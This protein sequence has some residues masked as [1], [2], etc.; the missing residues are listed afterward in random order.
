MGSTPTVSDSWVVTT[1][2]KPWRILRRAALVLAAILL[3]ALGIN[4][5][6]VQL[7]AWRASK[8]RTLA[9]DLRA[10]ED[11]LNPGVL[12]TEPT[13]WAGLEGAARLLRDAGRAAT[14]AAEEDRAKRLE[15]ESQSAGTGTW[16]PRTNWRLDASPARIARRAY[17][18]EMI[19]A[20]MAPE[21]R[22]E[23]ER[24]SDAAA[25]DAIGRLRQDYFRQVADA[26]SLRNAR[27]D[28]PLPSGGSAHQISYAHL[29]ATSTVLEERAATM[30][31]ARERD[32]D[33]E[34]FEA[35]TQALALLDMLARQP[36]VWSQM[37][38]EIAA[39]RVLDGVRGAII[40]RAREGTVDEAWLGQLETALRAM[41]PQLRWEPALKAVEAASL[42]SAAYVYESPSSLR[43]API[44]A[45]ERLRQHETGM[46]LAGGYRQVSAWRERTRHR[47]GSYTLTRSI[48]SGRLR[49]V[50]NSVLEVGPS[51]LP[52]IGST[53][54]VAA[55]V[56]RGGAY[57]SS[58]DPARI[59]LKLRALETMLA[60]ERWNLRQGEYPQQLTQEV[61]ALVPPLVS[62]LPQVERRIPPRIAPPAKGT[63]ASAS[64]ELD[65]VVRRMLYARRSPPEGD[66]T[67]HPHYALYLTGPDGVDHGGVATERPDWLPTSA[68]PGQDFVLSRSSYK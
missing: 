19:D 6:L 1:L 32:D 26:A 67:Q 55:L 4:E 63:F 27:H 2:R 18:E 60:I 9:A 61:F 45:G 58:A 28:K 39:E 62:N 24:V 34:F 47:M 5:M 8:H 64:H 38:A 20:S 35:L 29:N 59:P 13:P 30:A 53:P 23:Y 37:R 65:D 33:A 66:K 54:Y 42:D 22:A 43:F 10:L 11:E 44:W 14:E 17:V 31:L 3:L 48:V 49:E 36:S 25:R 57:F 40:A 51:S 41:P 52:T 21:V 16:R 50:R 7:D 15:E 46:T 68:A 56:L 12:A